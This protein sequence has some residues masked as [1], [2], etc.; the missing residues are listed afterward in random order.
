MIVMLR[1]AFVSGVVLFVAGCADWSKPGATPE[2]LAAD[3]SACH[4]KARSAFPPDLGPGLDAATGAAQPSV[5][6]APNRGCVTT[7]AAAPVGGAIADR[8]AQVR[9]NAFDQCMMLRG[10][11]K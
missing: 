2:A 5:S 11:S 3:Q 1:L 10:W 8:N 7:G 9:D 6:C 4:D